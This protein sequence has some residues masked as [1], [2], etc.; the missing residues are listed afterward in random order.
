VGRVDLRV[1][2]GA[3]VGAVG[4]RPEHPLLAGRRV[5]RI[6]VVLQHGEVAQ[7]RTRG[8]RHDGALLVGGDRHVDPER[9]VARDRREARRRDAVNGLAPA[10]DGVELHLDVD[11]PFLDAHGTRDARVNLT[12]EADRRLDAGDVDRGARARV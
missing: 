12:A 2:E 9:D 4:Q 7:Q 11:R 10:L 1:G 8:R 5:L 3:I 6:A